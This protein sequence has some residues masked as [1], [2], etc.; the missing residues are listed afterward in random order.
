[1]RKC[2]VTDVV[3]SKFARGLDNYE[4]NTGKRHALRSEGLST[5]TKH[6]TD[7]LDGGY[8]GIWW[9]MLVPLRNLLCLRNCLT[10]NNIFCGDAPGEWSVFLILPPCSNLVVVRAERVHGPIRH[11]YIGLVPL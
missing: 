5:G 3:Y 4:R 11:Q 1:M 7:N 6:A 10:G 9:G 2:M 8:K